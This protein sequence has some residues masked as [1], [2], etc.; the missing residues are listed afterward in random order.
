M[1]VPVLAGQLSMRRTDCIQC[2]LK[3]TLLFQTG[4]KQ[5]N[6]N[7]RDSRREPVPAAQ[8]VEEPESGLLTATIQNMVWS[9]LAAK[10]CPA[11][12]CSARAGTAFAISPSL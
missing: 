8:Q 3:D 5:V 6:S 12:S 1:S 10:C 4:Q 2:S 9:L 11:G 7:L